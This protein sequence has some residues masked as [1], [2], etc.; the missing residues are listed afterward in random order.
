MSDTP[1]SSI[2]KTFFVKRRPKAKAAAK[3][4]VKPASN[5]NPS[6]NIATINDKE[7]VDNLTD[8]EK[9]VLSIA[10]EHLE[11]SFSLKRSNGYL[12]HN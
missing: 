12:S 5:T 6:L 10:I 9:E 1:L 11:T 4:K 2:K 3:P 7:Y 8:V